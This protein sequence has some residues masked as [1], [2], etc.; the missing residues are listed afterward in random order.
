MEKKKRI[1]RKP[2][3][4][5]PSSELI[6]E[7]Q[8][9]ETETIELNMTEGLTE[10]CEVQKLVPRIS[11]Q[12]RDLEIESSC[13]HASKS[14]AMEVE[15]ETGTKIE[16]ESPKTKSPWD[17]FPKETL[18]RDS[19]LRYAEP[20]IKDGYSNCSGANPP[21]AVF[22]G[23]IKR[24]WNHLGIVQVA[25][26][27]MGLVMVKFHDEAS[28]DQVLE[29]GLIHFDR[30]PVI[31]R[32]WTT[33]LNA[34]KLHT[35][36]RT[37]IQF[38]RVLVEMEITDEPPSA[39]PY[40]NEF[41]QLREQKIDY[42]WIPAKC[43]KCAGFGH[44]QEDCR[45]DDTKKKTGGN[46]HKQ[47]KND[48]PVKN[49][50]NKPETENTNGEEGA[51]LQQ[52]EWSAPKKKIISSRGVQDTNRDMIDQ[53]GESNAF[54]ALQEQNVEQGKEGNSEIAG[55]QVHCYVKMTGAV[56]EF[57]VTI[58]YGFNTIEARKS[59]WEEMKNLRFPVKPW[60]VVGDFNAVFELDDRI[61]ANN[62]T[63]NDIADS[64][65][66]LAQANAV[67]LKKTGSHYTWTNNQEDKSRIYSRIDHAF[68]NEDSV[69]L[70]PDAKAHFDWELISDHCS[71]V[72]SI[73]VSERIGSLFQ[74]HEG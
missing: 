18:N 1:G 67:R 21:I 53:V 73:V 43:K 16:Q 56:S 9:D 55:D 25:R 38:A 4:R 45:R 70:L 64:N 5:Q 3:L 72:I 30:K 22:E 47:G 27:T 12:S 40:F 31:V 29:E 49:K 32:P 8:G 46:D 62:I 13:S 33:D 10:D 54:I 60:L 74:A 23:F 68:V 36:D 42:E 26:M 17:N 44:I 61:W 52:G 65:N 35:K 14:W 15:E 37:R 63:L 66:W 59:L 71:C 19:K 6:L 41:F 20:I 2:I 28:R 58:V 7:A 69:D 48:L 34:V 39:I 50:K 24:L 57:Y 51:N 11:K